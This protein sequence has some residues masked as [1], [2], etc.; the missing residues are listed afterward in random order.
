MVGPTIRASAADITP[1]LRALRFIDC[2]RLRIPWR[3]PEG[4]MRILP[5]AVK[6]NRFLA[7]DFVFI[8]GILSSRVF[9]VLARRLGMPWGLRTPGLTIALKSRGL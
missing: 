4:F 9:E 7:D 6:R 2:D 5:E 8:L 1:I 3:M